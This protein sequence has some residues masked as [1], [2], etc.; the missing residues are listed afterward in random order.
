MDCYLWLISCWTVRSKFKGMF[1]ADEDRVEKGRVLDIFSD[2]Q[3]VLSQP[4][5]HVGLRL[6][7]GFSWCYFTFPVQQLMRWGVRP[8]G[9]LCSGAFLV[10]D[11][12]FAGGCSICF[13]LQRSCRSPTREFQAFHSSNHL[14]LQRYW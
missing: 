11:C 14:N 4:K 7:Q 9:T 1:R 10:R 13:L 5:S 6:S 2:L 12:I 3:T 8:G